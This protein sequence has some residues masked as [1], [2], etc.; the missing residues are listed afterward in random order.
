MRSDVLLTMFHATKNIPIFMCRSVLQ[1]WT[2]RWEMQRHVELLALKHSCAASL[3]HNTFSLAPP[4]SSTMKISFW[5]RFFS[6]AIEVGGSFLLSREGKNNASRW[7]M[8]FHL[9]CWFGKTF[10]GG[11]RRDENCGWHIWHFLIIMWRYRFCVYL[12]EKKHR[13]MCLTLL[14]YAI[15]ADVAA[16]PRPRPYPKLREAKIFILCCYVYIIKSKRKFSR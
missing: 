8:F 10:F 2:L 13:I 15:G 12:G 6:H 3:N 1:K 5:C 7:N 16:N 14:W 4:T 11:G 9:F